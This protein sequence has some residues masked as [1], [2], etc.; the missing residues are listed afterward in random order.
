[1]EQIKHLSQ[2]ISFII[3]TKNKSTN[4]PTHKVDWSPIV[5]ENTTPIPR[6]NRETTQQTL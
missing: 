6:E 3:P 2:V 1:M 4:Q 5:G